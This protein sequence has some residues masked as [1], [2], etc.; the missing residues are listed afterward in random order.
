MKRIF[1]SFAVSSALLFSHYSLS[2]LLGLNDS[3]LESLH[4]QI[5]MAD[6]N[7]PMNHSANKGVSRSDSSNLESRVSPLDLIGL[8]S[9][10]LQLSQ[11]IELDLEIQTSF[12][13]EYIDP[14]GAGEEG[15]EGSLLLSGVHIGSSKTPLTTDKIQ[16]DAPFLASE[17]ALIN[18]ILIDV[19]SKAGMFITI[20]QLGDKYGNGID[21][22]VNDVYLGGKD[23]SAGGIL[24]EDISNFIQ[25]SNV[26]TNNQLFSMNL[27]TL[28]DGK[29]TANGNWVPFYSKVLP[30]EGAG[31]QGIDILSSDLLSDT[32]L[33]GLSA[34][35]IIDASF[36]LSIDKVAWVDDGNEFGLAG[37]MVYQGIDTDNDGI[38]DTVG[39]ARLTQMKL[40]TV[41]H[42]AFDGSDVEALYIENLDFKADIA[43]QSIYVGQPENSLGALHIK[44][45]DT[46]GTSVWVYPH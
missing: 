42:K 18:N 21:V 17:L 41:D 14:D 43:I 27:S 29:Q 40:E 44:G 8:D 37:F 31:K 30:I 11:G 33:P 46:A 45:L 2:A 4:G 3:E 6:A 26:E 25:D 7:A 16:S 23:N 28:D 35:T 15:A 34:N 1:I 22:I 32:G 36:V 5:N 10:D 38:D 12:D 19:D 20:E 39:P 24:I 13:F 9:S